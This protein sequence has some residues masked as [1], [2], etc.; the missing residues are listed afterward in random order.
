MVFDADFIA[1]GAD[2]APDEDGTQDSAEQGGFRYSSN[3]TRADARLGLGD[4]T[5]FMPAGATGWRVYFEVADCDAAAAQVKALDG[6]LL[7]GPTDSPFGR[8]ATI[9]A[10]EGATFQIISTA[11]ATD[12]D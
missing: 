3:G 10:P 4:V 6:A 2:G 11:Q 9:A 5:G 12:V 1:M 7:D 8:L